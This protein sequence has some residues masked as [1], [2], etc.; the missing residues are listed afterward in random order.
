[1]KRRTYNLIVGIF[2][3]VGILIAIF[4]LG[5]FGEA[6]RYLRNYATYATFFDESVHAL[7]PNAAVTYLGI[8]IGHIKSLQV[9]PDARHVEV[10]VQISRPELI[11]KD[12]YAQIATTGL[13]GGNYIDIVPVPPDQRVPPPRLDFAVPYPVIP[14][15][16]SQISSLLA[17][18]QAIVEQVRSSDIQRTFQEVDRTI[19]LAGDFL[20]SSELKD[21]VARLDAASRNLDRTIEGLNQALG[22]GELQD[23]L[24]ETRTTLEGATSLL[25]QLTTQAE[26]AGIAETATLARSTLEDLGRQSRLLGGEVGTTLDNLRQAS[27]SLNRLLDRLYLRPSDLLFSQPPPARRGTR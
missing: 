7:E 22:T 27:E 1:M 14:S 8:G 13:T 16:P 4:A 26:A 11:T 12:V 25:Q 15:Q 24:A 18:A 6:Q 5:Y 23:V 17:S 19:A 3:V 10:I 2:V 20:G 21:I 9:A